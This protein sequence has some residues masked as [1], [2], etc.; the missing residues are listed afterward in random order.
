MT[1]ACIAAVYLGAT[2][3][4]S[5]GIGLGMI[6][7]PV[8]AV[9]DPAFIPVAII[10]AV[11]PLTFTIAWADRAHVV[12]RDIGFALLGRLPGVFLGALV[13]AALSDQVLAVMVAVSVLFAVVVSLT[14]RRF[15]PSPGSLVVAG[16]ASG[17]TG[18]ATGVG[19]P[20]MAL[21]YQHTDPAR[22]RSTLSA[23]FAIGALMSLAALTVA[24]QVGVLQLQL[25]AMILPPVGLGLVTARL[26]RHRLDASIVRPA[27]LGVCT[28]TSFA[29]LLETV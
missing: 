9:A 19:G 20:P 11:I 3:Q 15:H 10:L 17:F 28:L 26:V 24:G 1:V 25:T 23:F 21:A 18:T 13:V 16:L 5:I 29:L 14:G 2:V 7:A 6:S 4:S 12:G 22:M 8:L 27:V